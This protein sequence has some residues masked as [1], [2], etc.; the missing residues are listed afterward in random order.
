MKSNYPV[1]LNSWLKNYPHSFQLV[2][3]KEFNNLAGP[4]E[5]GSRINFAATPLSKQ[6]QGPYTQGVVL[7]TKEAIYTNTGDEDVWDIKITMYGHGTFYAQSGVDNYKLQVE[8][9][10]KIESIYFDTLIF[11]HIE[12]QDTEIPTTT[13]IPNVYVPEEP[14]EPIPEDP[15]PPE[16]PPPDPGDPPITGDPTQISNHGFLFYEF[17]L[18]NTS[19]LEIPAPFRGMSKIDVTHQRVTFSGTNEGLQLHWE[20][21]GLFRTFWSGL[22][23]WIFKNWAGGGLVAL[24]LRP[25]PIENFYWVE[26]AY[27]YSSVLYT[28][29]AGEP[30][31]EMIIKLRRFV[32]EG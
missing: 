26:W 27:T 2:C 8:K 30:A 12:V 16:E 14:P 29:W 32:G 25:D 18:W 17:F 7:P 9:F 3:G 22:W 15:P 1:S 31:E 11:Q 21:Y 20:L 28:P 13:E 5:N 19:A 4:W 10:F 6:D 24:F 23:V